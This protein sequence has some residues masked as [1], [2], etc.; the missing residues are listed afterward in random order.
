M[1]LTRRFNIAF[2]SGPEAV[3]N[4]GM[5]SGSNCTNVNSQRSL[6]RK[7]LK[8]GNL[9]TDPSDPRK[10]GTR[11]PSESALRKHGRTA[12]CATIATP[13]AAQALKP[14]ARHRIRQGPCYVPRGWELMTLPHYGLPDQVSRCPKTC[15][16]IFLRSLTALALGDTFG[17][18]SRCSVYTRPGLS[19]RYLSQA[20]SL[21]TPHQVIRPPY[22]PYLYND[23]LLFPPC[24]PH[25]PR[26]LC[27][28]R[29]CCPGPNHQDI[30]PQRQ[31]RWS[32]ELEGHHDRH[33]HW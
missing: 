20:R 26:R 12:S 7:S 4:G 5:I 22:L 6:E 1:Q 25:Y 24:F 21:P 2:A 10:A 9:G 3:I 31:G 27:H 32:G 11:L 15:A 19:N 28:R 14:K 16:Q 29:L 13:C 30:G 17:K 8:V 23:V 18:F 33:Q